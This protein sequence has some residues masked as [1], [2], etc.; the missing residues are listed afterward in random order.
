[1]LVQNKKGR[2]EMAMK[3]SSCVF[4]DGELMGAKYTCDGE[5]ISPPL[6]CQGVPEGAASIALI[7][8]DPDAPMRT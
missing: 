7:C 3:L 8:D 6:Q 4:A 1:M 5:D 2:K